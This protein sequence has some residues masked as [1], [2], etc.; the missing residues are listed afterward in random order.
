MFCE[1]VKV[2]DIQEQLEVLYPD[3]PSPVFVYSRAQVVDNVR[4]DGGAAEHRQ[5]VVSGRTSTS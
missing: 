5:G 4:K 3:C 1:N 2:K